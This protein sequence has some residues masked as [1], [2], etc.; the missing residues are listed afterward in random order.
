MG[1]VYISHRLEELIRI[2]DYITVLRDGVITGSRS[3][4][5]VDIPWIVSNM[6]GSAS[7]EFPKTQPHDLGEEVFRVEDVCLPRPAGAMWSTTSPCRCA[8]ARSSGSTG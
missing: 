8:P 7:K 3:M 5:G 6:I 4:E 2:G 1:I